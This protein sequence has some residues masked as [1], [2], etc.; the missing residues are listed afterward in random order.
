MSVHQ[1]APGLISN[2]VAPG[3]TPQNASVSAGWR[4]VSRAR[5]VAERCGAATAAM[6]A[7]SGLGADADGGGADCAVA[8]PTGAAAA[9]RA[10]MT[11]MLGRIV[12]LSVGRSDYGQRE[13][14]VEPIVRI[15]ETMLFKARHGRARSMSGSGRCRS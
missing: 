11:S 9:S 5:S 14:M 6:R 4:H 3:R 10:A 13:G 7:G 15:A 2:T 1:P 12:F 8:A